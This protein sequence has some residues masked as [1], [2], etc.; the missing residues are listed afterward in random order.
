MGIDSKESTDVTICS[1]QNNKYWGQTVQ[2]R[3]QIRKVLTVY[4]TLIIK[5]LVS[6]DVTIFI[7]QYKTR[8]LYYYVTTK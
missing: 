4:H 1:N 7:Y 8:L 6:A 2:R 5:V 3:K